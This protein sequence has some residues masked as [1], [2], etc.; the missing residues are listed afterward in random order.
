MGIG[1]Y[2]MV[3]QLNGGMNIQTEKP[4]FQLVTKRHTIWVKRRYSTDE[5]H[6]P[7]SML[8]RQIGQV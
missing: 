2:K 6:A 4:K 3:E 5:I 8:K 7:G 1:I